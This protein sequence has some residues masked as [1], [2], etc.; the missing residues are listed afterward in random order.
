M[1]FVP[2]RFLLAE[3]ASN[4]RDRFSMGLWRNSVAGPPSITGVLR[5]PIDRVR[6]LAADPYSGMDRESLQI[7][8]AR[9]FPSQ[10]S[11]NDLSSI[12][13]FCLACAAACA[14]GYGLG[15]NGRTYTRKHCS[16]D[17]P[18]NF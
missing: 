4:L 9:D 6:T 3:P 14:L 10:Q 15:D 1:K 16:P 18:K 17:F 8:S 7:F 5:K 11:V 12:L 2:E 13:M